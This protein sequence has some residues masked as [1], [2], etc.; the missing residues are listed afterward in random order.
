MLIFACYNSHI[1]NLNTIE[2]TRRKIVA[3]VCLPPHSAHKLHPLDNSFNDSPQMFY[4]DIS[5]LC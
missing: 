5:T 4:G 3:A 1:R 2:L